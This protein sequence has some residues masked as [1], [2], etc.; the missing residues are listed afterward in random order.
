MTEPRELTVANLDGS[1]RRVVTPSS[2]R[3]MVR[4]RLRRTRAEAEAK[5]AE[6]AADVEAKRDALVVAATGRRRRCRWARAVILPFY[7]DC[8]PS[9]QQLTRGKEGR[10]GFDKAGNDS[11]VGWLERRDATRSLRSD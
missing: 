7:G 4:E 10:G 6:G 9:E 3:A 1:V 8:P 5:A 2:D 11:M